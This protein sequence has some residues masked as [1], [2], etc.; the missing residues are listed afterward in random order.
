MSASDWTGTAY[1]DSS[2]ILKLVVRE[3]ETA[4]LEAHLATRDGLITSRLSV[5][6]CRRAVRRAANRRLLQ[7]V[8]GVFEALYLLDITPALLDAA[9][10]VDPPLLRSL[11]AIHL[12]T[13]RSIDPHLELITYDERQADAARAGGFVVLAPGR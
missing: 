9:A 10:S 7:A 3:P 1:V 6:E 5:L 8:E 13:A 12:A 4:A 2:A 11:D